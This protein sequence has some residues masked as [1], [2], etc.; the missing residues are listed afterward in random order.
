MTKTEPLDHLAKRLTERAFT[1]SE[2]WY[3][4]SGVALQA[5]HEHATGPPDAT[6]E[7]MLDLID[8]I[9]TVARALRSASVNLD[10]WR[11]GAELPEIRADLQT[12]N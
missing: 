6:G 11:E 9:Q 1:E 2:Y 7:G 8:V 4:A 5:F 3:D 10:N 12:D